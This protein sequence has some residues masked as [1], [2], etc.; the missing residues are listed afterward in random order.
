MLI[1]SQYR[2]PG[3]S[4]G[5][6]Y[7]NA[8]IQGASVHGIWSNLCREISYCKVVPGTTSEDIPRIFWQAV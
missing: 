4:P 7:E 8:C 3:H 6:S 5:V 2:W 1:T